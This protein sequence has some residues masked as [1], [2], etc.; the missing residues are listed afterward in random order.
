MRTQKPLSA[1]SVVPTPPGEGEA[2]RLQVLA[3]P[4]RFRIITA[5]DSTCVRAGAVVEATGVVQ[6]TVSHD[7]RVLRDAG[8]VVGERRGQQIFYGRS[9][10]VGLVQRIRDLELVGA[11]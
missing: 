1:M 10:V 5:V 11:S 6:P 2:R 8:L 3:D 9:D 4:T 7:R